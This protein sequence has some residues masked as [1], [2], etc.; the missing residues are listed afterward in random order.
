[1]GQL[2]YMYKALHESKMSDSAKWEF[3]Q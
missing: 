1:L 2:P 3:V